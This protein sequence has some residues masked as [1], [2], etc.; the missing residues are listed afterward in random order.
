MP[1]GR[2]ASNALG[3]AP[4][5]PRAAAKPCWEVTLSG[6]HV[7]AAHATDTLGYMLAVNL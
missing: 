7:I 3:C 6:K 2:G 1:A 4:V 5:T